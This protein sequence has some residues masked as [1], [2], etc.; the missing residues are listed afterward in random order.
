MDSDSQ[1]Q[2]SPVA[3]ESDGALSCEPSR[4]MG[5]HIF[6]DIVVDATTGKEVKRTVELR[7]RKPKEGNPVD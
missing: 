6:V 7:D 4:Y 1:A 3:E 2:K 5:P